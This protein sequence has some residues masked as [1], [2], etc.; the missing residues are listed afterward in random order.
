MRPDHRIHIITVLLLVAGAFVVVGCDKD[1]DDISSAA[2]YLETLEET[3]AKAREIMDGPPPPAGD[4]K[5]LKRDFS[6]AFRSFSRALRDSQIKVE[7]EYEGSS[8]A[9][10]LAKLQTIQKVYE[11]TILTKLSQEGRGLQMTLAVPMADFR[12]SYE[13]LDKEVQALSKMIE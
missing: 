13:A 3:W 5:T 7:E 11:E 8:K 2:Y 9:E 10:L 6:G 1:I 12:K 4:G